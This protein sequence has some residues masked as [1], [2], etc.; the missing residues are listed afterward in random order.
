MRW[1]APNKCLHSSR[2][3]AMILM[4]GR[5]LRKQ[6]RVSAG[7]VR[8]SRRAFQPL[9]PP[10]F[11]N[12]RCTTYGFSAPVLGVGVEN[13]VGFVGERQ[14]EHQREKQ[15]NRRRQPLQPHRRSGP[16]VVTGKRQ[17]R[18]KQQQRYLGL[19]SEIHS[20]CCNAMEGGAGRRGSWCCAGVRRRIQ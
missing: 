15:Q 8:S 14:I 4:L 11:W 1:T 10:Q 16:L 18:Q 20:G 6:G 7:S 9:R 5:F 12:S 17:Q 3:F 13:E 19:L 2:R